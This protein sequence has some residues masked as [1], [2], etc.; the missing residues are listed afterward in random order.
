DANWGRVVMAAGKSGE[1]IDLNALAIWFGD[2]AV[3]SGGARAA[4]YD[5]ARATAA[6]SEPE[7]AI[8]MSVGS[9]PGKATVY[10]CD[11]T[12]GYVDINGAYRT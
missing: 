3:A 12:H 11:L 5:E 7:I 9:G 10:T 6:V 1:T 2:I 8:R 4:D